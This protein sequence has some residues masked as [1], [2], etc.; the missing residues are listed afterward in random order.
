MRAMYRLAPAVCLTAGACVASKNDVRILQ[1]DL[2]V[3]RTESAQ[4]DSVRARQLELLIG[5]LQ[6]QR[7]SMRVLSARLQKFQGDAAGELFSI[8]QQLIQVQELTGQSQR[9]LQE[10]RA[11]LEERAQQAAAPPPVPA[12]GAP[13]DSAAA[14]ATPGPNQLFQLALDQF[15]RG[16]TGAARLGF[17][18]LLRQYPQSDLVPDARFYVGETYDQEGNAAAADSAY[19]TVVR[20]FPQAP[21]AATALYKHA[22]LMQRAGRTQAARTALNQVIRDYPRSDEASLARERLRTLR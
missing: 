3:M 9:R 1:N 18:D 8:G 16:S 19:Q 6:T 17:E 15:R 10:V 7:D 22:L 20:Q 4:A 11:A 12:P 21:R 14:G 2:Q 13:V 5:S